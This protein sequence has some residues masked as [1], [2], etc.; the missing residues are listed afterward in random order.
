MECGS[1]E[2]GAVDWEDMGVVVATELERVSE[3][4]RMASD[5]CGSRLRQGW[6]RYVRRATLGF[7]QRR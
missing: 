5:W 4:K 3:G 2:T 1:G 7:R 6:C